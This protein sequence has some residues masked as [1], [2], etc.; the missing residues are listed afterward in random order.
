MTSDLVS[1]Q[2]FFDRVPLSWCYTV[3]TLLFGLSLAGR[4]AAGG[5]LYDHP[6]LVF[7]PAILGCSLL[8]GRGTGFYVT[9]IGGVASGRG[10]IG[11]VPVDLLLYGFVGFGASWAVEALRDAGLALKQ[12]ED[13]KVAL[14]AEM[15]HRVK[16]NIQIVLGLLDREAGQLGAGAIPAARYAE[17]LGGLRERIKVVARLHDRFLRCEN[18]GGAET[19]DVGA[20]FADL[21]QDFRSTL[22]CA[23]PIELVVDLAR[24]RVDAR[25]A[26]VL[27]L[28]LN[29]LVTNAVKH[30]FPPRRARGQI[31]VT[32]ELGGGV[33]ELAVTDDGVGYP[34]GSAPGSG[35]GLVAAFV[36][37][38]NGVIDVHSVPEVGTRVAVRIP[39]SWR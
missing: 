11:G 26:L 1:A 6:L 37:Q 27:G 34:E 15:N 33:Y 9:V 32:F 30:A 19:V 22:I 16:N 20:F 23:R 5:D 14:L 21:C 18:G 17:L 3:A 8:A 36:R 39:R 24:I 4:A 10:L 31:E 13:S 28:I 35:A 7:L 25:T 29:E 38:L 2:R 12:A